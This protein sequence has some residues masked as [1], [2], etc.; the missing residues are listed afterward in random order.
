MEINPFKDMLQ[1]EGLEAKRSKKKGG[2]RR[3]KEWESPMMIQLYN[4]KDVS[5]LQ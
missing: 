5:Y 3:R 2:R 1:L 4:S